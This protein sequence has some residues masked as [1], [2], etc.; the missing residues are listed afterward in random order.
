MRTLRVLGGLRLDDGTGGPSSGRGAQRRRLA[1]LALLAL[2]PGR[3]ITR[4]KAIATLW[5]EN[6]SAEGRRRLSSAVYDLRGLLGDDAIES[7]GDELWI[8]TTA[9]FRVDVD[10]FEAAF[11]HGDAEG[12]IAAYGGALL[13]GVHLS[14]A[15]EF[16]E[17]VASQRERFRRQYLQALE[18]AA[19][20]RMARGDHR[21]AVAAALQLVDLEPLSGSAAL[22][23]VN[24]LVAAGDRARA[25]S[26]ADAHAAR[27][28]RELGV[29]PDDA[30]VEAASRLR[31]NARAVIAQE[32]P[33][34]ARDSRLESPSVANVASANAPAGGVRIP[35]GSQVLWSRVAV[36]AM[37]VG[38]VTGVAFA[39]RAA[40]SGESAGTIALTGLAADASRSTTS[41]GA[42]KSFIDGEN[43]YKN[44][45]YD[46]A[47]KSFRAAIGQDSTFALAH[48]RLGQ[49]MLWQEQPDE[50]AAAHDS[51]A[52]RWSSNLSEQDRRLIRAYLAWRRGDYET[53]DSLDRLAF[54]AD[55]EDAEVQF[56][57]A[58]V[59][60]HYN[61]LRGRSVGQAGGQLESVLKVDSTNWGARWH[62][63]LLRASRVSETEFQDRVAQLLNARPDGH[64]AAELRLFAADRRELPRL[65]ASATPAMLYDAAW[66]RA[67]FRRDLSGAETLLVHMTDRN[68]S[69]LD[70][71][72]A[73]FA[74]AALRI[75]R[76]RTAAALPLLEVEPAHS[77]NGSESK[78]ILIHGLLASPSDAAVDTDTLGRVVE[79]WRQT[80]AGFDRPEGDPGIIARYLE[81]LLSG[82]RHDSAGARAA[83]SELELA[84]R[85]PDPYFAVAGRDASELAHTV[86]AYLDFRAGR[87]AA[88]FGELDAERT[89][90]WLGLIASSALASRSFER[91]IRAECLLS[92]G[93]NAEAIEW[94]ETLEQGTL[95][96]LEFL[97]ASL[98][99]QAKAHRAMGQAE[100]AG[101]IERRLSDLYEEGRR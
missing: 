27:V 98:R 19:A 1:L 18:Q 83:A 7:A 26:V 60:F 42:L 8:A 66:R 64:L 12:A 5:P 37:V 86:R 69:D 48:Y 94:F 17:W 41:A 34:P 65:A 53:A 33:P 31:A 100:A 30:V 80:L 14:G 29:D 93:R 49:S 9:E 75:G 21:G 55:P 78:V 28:R 89:P 85:R 90:I 32:S 39:A 67:V 87:C 45:R 91:W 72:S 95:Y 63:L 58:E 70:R 59:M 82:A 101:A 15:A 71:R 97:A 50:F 24:A 36:A 10:E 61:P 76:G 35:R 44:G 16:E 3:R 77:V 25:L 46:A 54:A 20:E 79:R 99:G 74:S 40:P 68:P 88:A 11:A 4:D 22:V 57:W 96:D 47:V 84:A 62:L 81:G 6:T 52:L 51:L 23:A 13:D 2:S 56:Q 92:L 43:A 73:A 38:G